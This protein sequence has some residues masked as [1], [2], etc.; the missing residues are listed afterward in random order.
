MI[1]GIKKN[2]LRQVSMQQIMSGIA[3]RPAVG[4]DPVVAVT[5]PAT[6]NP[7]NRE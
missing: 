7:A 4:T 3:H 5:H 1:T 6:K 2:K